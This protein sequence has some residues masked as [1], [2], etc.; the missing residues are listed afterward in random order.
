MKLACRQ[1]IDAPAAFV[2]AQISDFES[3]ERTAMRRGVE[4]ERTDKLS[5]Y[6]S[7]TSWAT[8]FRYRGRERRVAI[9]LERLAADGHA[10]FSVTSAPADGALEVEIVAMAASRV[11]MLVSIEFKPKTFAAKLFVQSLRL[12]RSRVERRLAQRAKALANE[13]EARYRA[14]SKLASL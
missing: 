1:D 6:G 13:I 14:T 10:D 8:R 12:A 11:R 5:A 3:W 4:I 9:R 2:L 7:G